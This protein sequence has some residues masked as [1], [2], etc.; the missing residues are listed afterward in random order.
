MPRYGGKRTEPGYISSIC[1]STIYNGDTHTH[2]YI[3]T[4]EVG[5]IK[6]EGIYGVR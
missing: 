1:E 2:I 5:D 4:P 6:N 3:Y